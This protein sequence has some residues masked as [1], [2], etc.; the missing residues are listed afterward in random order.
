MKISYMKPRTHPERCLVVLKDEV[1]ERI[2]VVPQV[3][4][5]AC[6]HTGYSSADVNRDPGLRRK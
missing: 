2:S 3:F 6:E 5:F 4:L 1:P